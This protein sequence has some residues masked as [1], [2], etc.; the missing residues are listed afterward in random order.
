MARRRARTRNCGDEASGE[1]APPR[2]QRNR[3]EHAC[4]A[5]YGIRPPE[6]PRARPLSIYAGRPSRWLQLPRQIAFQVALVTTL[7]LYFAGNPSTSNLPL[8]A[9]ARVGHIG[10]AGDVAEWLKAAVC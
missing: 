3:V 5:N 8:A 2:A 9:C 7:S 6:A 1:S 10:L 4:G